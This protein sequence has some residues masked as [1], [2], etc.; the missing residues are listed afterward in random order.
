MYLSGWARLWI[1]FTVLWVASVGGAWM[2]ANSLYKE[3]NQVLY[4]N[5]SNE[6]IEY[7]VENASELEGQ[8]VAAVRSKYSDMSEKQTIAALREKFESK[9]PA[10]RFGFAEIDGR[11]RPLRTQVPHSWPWWFGVAIG[12]PVLVFAIAKTVVWIVDGFR[13]S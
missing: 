1:V 11:Y 8:T 13:S 9:H 2:Y 10:Y 12:I 3:A 7:L 4:K 5:W 6:M